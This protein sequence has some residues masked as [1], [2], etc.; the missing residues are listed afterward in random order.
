MLQRINFSAYKLYLKNDNVS[1]KDSSGYYLPK[2]LKSKLQTILN[3]FLLFIFSKCWLKFAV[4]QIRPGLSLSL[5]SWNT[6][7]FDKIDW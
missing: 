3:H 5:I 2:E 1:K 6:L 4:T 7:F